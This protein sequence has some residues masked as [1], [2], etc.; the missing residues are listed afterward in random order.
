MSFI[1][2]EIRD[3]IAIPSEIKK[4]RNESQAPGKGDI[5][6]I[7]STRRE[8][9]GDGRE[10]VL[11]FV[12]GDILRFIEVFQKDTIGGEC[13]NVETAGHIFKATISLP[14]GVLDHLI[15]SPRKKKK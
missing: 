11:F 1:F 6:W 3:L 9:T 4:M 10:S 7:N 14:E 12:V 8:K 13:L 2:S 5:V 15:K